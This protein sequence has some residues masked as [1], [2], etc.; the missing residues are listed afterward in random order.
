MPPPLLPVA[1]RLI[2]GALV[3]LAVVGLGATLLRARLAGLGFLAVGAACVALA[4]LARNVPPDTPEVMMG[5]YLFPGLAAQMGLLA[6]GLAYFWRWGDR[7]L[8]TAARLSI[9]GLHAIF[10][11]FV[12]VPFLAGN[13]PR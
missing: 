12:F 2:L 11:T 9:L 10:I 13:P 3:G 4:L 7:G 8:R 5:R 6:A 1:V